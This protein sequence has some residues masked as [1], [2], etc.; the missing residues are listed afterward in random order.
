MADRLLTPALRRWLRTPVA[1]RIAIVYL[2][3]RL[4]TTAFLAL[5]ASQSSPL[6][7]FGADA[8]VRDY[9]LGWDAQWYWWVSENG[10][11][12]ELP[13]TD[14]GDVAENA[15]A[16]MP[17]YAFLARAVGFGD[18][19]TG[20]LLVSLVAGLLACF[21]LHRLLR[22]RIGASA[23][24]WAVAFFS[25]GPLA[26]LFQVGYAEA[27]FMLLLLV[28]LDLASRYR[29]AA[30]YLLIPV[31]GFTRPGV[32]AFSLFL[33]L[34]GIA[35]WVRRHDDPLPAAHVVHIVALGLLSAIVGFSW[36]LIAAVVTADPSA[37]L[38][39]ELAW[40][41]NWIQDASPVFVPFD[42]FVLGAQF[43]FRHWG[44]PGR[45]GVVALALLVV[46]AAWLLLRSAPVRRLGADLRLWS[47]SYLLYLLAVFFPQS[48][49]LR[50]LIPLSPLWGAAVPRSRGWRWAM[51]SACLLAQWLWIHSV[52]GLSQTFWQVP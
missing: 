13:R 27:L 16:F 22:D 44:M 2:V 8:T 14:S 6:S 31:M 32:L 26:A 24:M 12:V 45:V 10:Y 7:R 9:V 5:A 20:A 3:S 50:L 42:G 52:Y 37:Y 34:H 51:L 36:Q 4:I 46:G 18:W 29:Y 35:R 33:A 11:P 47:A 15:W 43:W 17:V 39:T 1:G 41:R 19:G 21:A 40:R 23:A 30:L 38:R 28:S 48:S 49:T 25:S